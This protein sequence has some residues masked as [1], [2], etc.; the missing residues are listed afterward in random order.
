MAILRR[1]GQPPYP[2][3]SMTRRLGIDL[4][5]LH[6]FVIALATYA[7]LAAP[8]VMFGDCAELA[9]RGGS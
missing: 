6:A 4:A 5:A 1:W 8:T 2:P 7:F 9:G 3:T